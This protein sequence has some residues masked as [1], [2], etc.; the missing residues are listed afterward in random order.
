ML[1]QM[2]LF[3]SFNGWVIFHC[4]Y[5]YYI[6]FIHSSVDGHLGCFHVLIIINYTAMNVGV[7]GFFQTMLF[8]GYMPRSGITGLYG[9]SIFSFLK[10]LLYCSLWCVLSCFSCVWFFATLWTVAHHAPLSMGFSRQECCRGFSCPPPGDL[11][12]SG[13]EPVPLLSPALVGGFI[14]TSTT[15]SCTNSHSHQQCRRVPSFP[16]P[17][18]I[19]CRFF[20]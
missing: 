9:S 14:T 3:H 2:T 17:S 6:L 19:H 5:I 18:S 1:L 12:D 10:K 7:Y 16:H 13:I 15:S 8:S 11:P 4:V 20:W